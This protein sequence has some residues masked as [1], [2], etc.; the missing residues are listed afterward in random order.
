M[1]ADEFSL[2]LNFVEE[3]L[4]A[5]EKNLKNRASTKDLLRVLN[6]LDTVTKRLEISGGRQIKIGYQ[7]RPL[8][9]WAELAAARIDIR[10]TH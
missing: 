2:L 6:L 10:P 1:N 7:S 4:K 8:R 3:C 9:K 5:I